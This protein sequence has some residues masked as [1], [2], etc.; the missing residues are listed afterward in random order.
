MHKHRRGARYGLAGCDDG[1]L[2]DPAR[3]ARVSNR[4][5]V[6][7][8]ERESRHFDAHAAGRPANPLPRCPITGA[9]YVSPCS[10]GLACSFRF[11]PAL[12]P[13]TLVET[14][15]YQ[16]HVEVDQSAERTLA[17]QL[18][19]AHAQ[20]ADLQKQVRDERYDGSGLALAKGAWQGDHFPTP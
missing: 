19:D 11:R 8:T 15:K 4:S 14:D 12:S 16:Q 18:K 13:F 9:C 3:D 10:I 2:A 17:G 5:L 1:L 7:G 20:I 6:P